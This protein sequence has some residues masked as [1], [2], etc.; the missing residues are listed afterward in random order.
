MGMKPRPLV[1]LLAMLALSLTRPSLAPAWGPIAHDIVNTWAIQTLPPEIRPFFESNRQFLVEHANDAD[2][3][4]KKDRYERMRH[5]I[6]LDKYGVFPYPALPHDYGHA[7]EQYSSWRINRDGSLPWQIGEY[8][9]RLTKAMKAGNWEEVKL[10][11]AD[12]AHYPP[13]VTP[14]RP[15]SENEISAI[16]GA[17]TRFEQRRE[18]VAREDDPAGG[19]A[20]GR[21]NVDRVPEPAEQVTRDRQVREIGDPLEREPVRVPR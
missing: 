12:L 2:E 17:V 18:R 6:Y 11:A 7:K 20:I 13:V 8:S 10:D 14:H 3:L 16:Q 1:L 9:L 21:V 15:G 19:P 5:Y 4:M